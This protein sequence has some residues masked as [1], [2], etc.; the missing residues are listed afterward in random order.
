[1]ATFFELFDCTSGIKE[2]QFFLP[3]F[4]ALRDKFPRFHAKEGTWT[5]QNLGNWATPITKRSRIRNSALK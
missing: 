2:I 4:H 5:S 1:M 3:N